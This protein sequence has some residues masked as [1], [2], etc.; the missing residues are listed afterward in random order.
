MF[1]LMITKLLP[2]D[3]KYIN[4][5]KQHLTSP[6]LP[7]QFSAYNDHAVPASFYCNGKG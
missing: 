5:S 1:L 4:S 6:R 3:V 2:C 7:K